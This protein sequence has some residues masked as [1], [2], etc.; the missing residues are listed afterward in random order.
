MG[1]SCAGGGFF[2]F[3]R[4][5]FLSFMHTPILK[6]RCGVFG[7]YRRAWVQASALDFL[8]SGMVSLVLI[9]GLGSKNSRIWAANPLSNARVATQRSRT[10][11]I[12]IHLSVSQLKRSPRRWTHTSMNWSVRR[13]TTP[14]VLMR[15]DHSSGP[16]WL[17][18]SS[19][20]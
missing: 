11:Q 2:D 4:Q 9:V 3:G 12:A 7:L 1:K 6:F 8:S 19:G 17:C 16:H 10:L 14:E 18:N 20:D 5:G 15:A 13:R